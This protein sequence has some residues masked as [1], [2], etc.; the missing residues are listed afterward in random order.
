M[1][2]PMLALDALSVRFGQFVAAD[3]VSLTLCAGETLALVGASGS[4]KSVA[5]R[6]IMQ[7]DPD[8]NYSGSVC[9]DGQELIGAP[10]RTL[11]ALRGRDVAMVF[12][13]PLSALNPVHRIGDQIA[14]TLKLHRGLRGQACRNAVVSLLERVQL[15]DTQRMFEA[16][17][18]QLSGGQRQRVL[19]AMALACEPRLLIADEPTTALDA[20]LRLEIMRLLKRL[21]DESGLALLIISHDL[22]LVREFATR[23]AVM[24]KGCI[25]EEGLV[26]EVMAHPRHEATRA[27][28][29]VRHARL[30]LPVDD[31]PKVLGACLLSC[32]YG[33][34]GWLRRRPGHQ[35]LKPMTLTL[36]AGETLAV[37]G[38][39]GSGKT[40]LALSL[41]RLLPGGEGQ[42]TLEDGVRFDALSG[43]ALR[44]AR[45]RMQLV[46]QDPFSSLS[47]RHTVLEIVS[48]GLALHRP[49]LDA[50]ARYARVCE[51]LAD[52]GLDESVLARYPHEFSGGQR[53]RIS[54][55]RALVVRPQI[56][57]LD[58]PTSALDAH[59][60][61]KV[62]EL[63]ATLQREH[64][65]A[66][67]LIT[68]DLAVVRALAHRMLVLN[69]GEVVEEGEVQTVFEQ[70]AHAYT[71]MLLEA[72][73]LTVA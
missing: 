65:I 69:G 71:R 25:V 18:H 57:V 47:P 31:A 32:R 23:V 33:A 72:S 14:E 12:Q 53:Q 52:V 30:A 59:V 39:S 46:P 20:H 15:S 58:E 1:T 43:P 62:L 5:A 55:A 6:A 61:V 22:A 35:A 24:A 4:G 19:I 54:L 50:D 48:E 67:V 9:F 63:L 8:A 66:F 2:A 37:V 36:K 11:R 27:L 56:V 13:E 26:D 41:L 49:G 28:L 21:A 7:L 29:A 60:A 44:A 17:P 73:G 42:I 64:C 45:A 38:E 34:G 68:H 3:S 16:Y 10:A 51:V 40:T 70:P